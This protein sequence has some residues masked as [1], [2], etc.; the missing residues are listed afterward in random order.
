MLPRSFLPRFI[1]SLFSTRITPRKALTRRLGV[2]LLEGRDVPSVSPLHLYELNGTL[3]DTLGGPTL[4][5]DGGV[6]NANRYVFN[7]NQGL[8]LSGGLADTTNYSVVMTASMNSLNPF[9]KKVID[10]Q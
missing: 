8:R 4:A 9:F 10:F 5:S 3:A 6:L 1:H 2:E 7:P